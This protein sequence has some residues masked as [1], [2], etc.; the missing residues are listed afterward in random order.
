MLISTILGTG[1]DNIM[2]KGWRAS[3]W[4]NWV[5]FDSSPDLARGYVET[6]AGWRS[7]CCAKICL[8][9]YGWYC[10]ICFS[11]SPS[12]FGDLVRQAARSPFH[13]VV[14]TRFPTTSRSNVVWPSCPSQWKH[15][16]RFSDSRV[17]NVSNVGLFGLLTFCWVD[18]GWSMM[19]YSLDWCVIC[20]IWSQACLAIDV[21]AELL[22]WSILRALW[23]HG[24]RSL[25]QSVRQ[26]VVKPAMVE[27]CHSPHYHYSH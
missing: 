11:S 1:C 7:W 5:C 26:S 14:F 23:S 8:W 13:P 20:G 24:A 9:M 21:A 16:E 27:L 3:S 25:L 10:S 17:R 12:R 19:K 22:N 6:L 18:M 2:G 15:G 4:F